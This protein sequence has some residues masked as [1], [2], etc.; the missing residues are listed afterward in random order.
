M[1]R[2]TVTEIIVAS[3]T[4]VQLIGRILRVAVLTTWVLFK[5]VAESLV[6]TRLESTVF[7]IIHLVE[8]ICYLC[9]K[10]LPE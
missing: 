8:A 9:L 4:L 2:H 10:S 1:C 3:L 5:E 6:I 7:A